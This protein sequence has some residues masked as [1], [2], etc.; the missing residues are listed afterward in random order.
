MQVKDG[1]PTARADVDD[2]PVVLEPDDP[3][4]VCHEL[5][6][7]LRLLADE[8]ADLAERVDVAL[9]DAPAGAPAPAG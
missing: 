7:A 1:L 9:R 4:R 6:H 3:R 8:L 2:H 5:E